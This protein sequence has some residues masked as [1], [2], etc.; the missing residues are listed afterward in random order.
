[1]HTAPQAAE[2]RSGMVNIRSDEDLSPEDV[3]ASYEPRHAQEVLAMK[4]DPQ[5]RPAA[6]LG[7]GSRQR[8]GA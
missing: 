8:L 7:W 1:M 6:A 3:L 4:D 2:V 5:V